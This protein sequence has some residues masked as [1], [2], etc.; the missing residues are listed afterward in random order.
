[1]TGVFIPSIWSLRFITPRVI[2]IPKSDPRSC[3]IKLRWELGKILHIKR[4]DRDRLGPS[5]RKINGNT[6]NPWVACRWSLHFLTP[7]ELSE[8]TV[9]VWTEVYP[10]HNDSHLCLKGI[11]VVEKSLSVFLGIP[12][13]KRRKEDLRRLG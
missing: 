8:A 6:I 11:W 7:I 12:E 10:V 5:R 2:G 1:M 3:L 4:W 9:H 13:Y